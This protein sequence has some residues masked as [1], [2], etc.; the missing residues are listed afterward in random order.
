M[1]VRRII[2]DLTY[3][4]SVSTNPTTTFSVKSRDFTSGEP[5]Q[6]VSGNVVRTISTPVEKYTDQLYLRARG[7]SMAVRVES[8]ELGTMWRLGAPRLDA[9]PDG[10]R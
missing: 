9:R 7:R 2:P 6:T 5:T 3:E 10:K 1:L 8:D 4:D